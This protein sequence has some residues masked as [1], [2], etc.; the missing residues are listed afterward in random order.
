MKTFLTMKVMTLSF[1]G[2]DFDQNCLPSFLKLKLSEQFVLI[3]IFFKLNYVHEFT[4]GLKLIINI[5]FG[6]IQRS[7][8]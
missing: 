1:G 8:Q 2:Q 3:E 5:S 7:T 6:L 4:I